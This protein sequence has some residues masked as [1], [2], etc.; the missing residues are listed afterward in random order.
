M[1][2]AGFQFG[3]SNTISVINGASCNATVT[4]GCGQK[5]ATVIVGVD[6]D[7]LAVDDRTDTIYVANNGT[8][9]TPGDTVSVIDGATCNGTHQSGCS[10]TPATIA[11][12]NY[13]SD[14]AID[15][16]TNTIYVTDG[17][18]NVS[19]ISGATC[20]GTDTAGCGQTP[21]T[22][23]VGLAPYQLAVDVATDTIYVGND[24]DN[25]LS[26]INGATCNG[27]V[28]TGCGQTP[29]AVP[30]EG[31]PFGVAVD[32]Q[33]NVVYLSS[34]WNSDAATINSMACN[35]TTIRGCEPTP[36]PVR[37]GGWPQ[38]FA[39]DPTTGTGYVPGNVD[40]TVSFF[41][42]GQQ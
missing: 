34:I 42:L 19:V 18:D 31:L 3:M 37:M 24:G 22:V 10:Q 25:T 4:S 35:P 39:F 2:N 14:V 28:S 27:T 12:L 9:M 29:P 13:P 16:R 21:T 40:G 20:D 33:T 23:T 1:A 32:Q 26:M 5:P 6:P 17:N 38:D 11:I 15:D 36:V 7:A 41:G 30:A 8:G